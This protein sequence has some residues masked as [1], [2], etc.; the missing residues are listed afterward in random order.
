MTHALANVSGVIGHP[1]LG[2]VFG[3]VESFL[4]LLLMAAASGIYNWLQK[5][6]QAGQR[7]EPFGSAGGSGEEGVPRPARPATPARPARPVGTPRLW[8]E[9][10]SEPNP[11]SSP[12][13]SDPFGWSLRE[14]LELEQPRE[15]APP[16]VP[17]APRVAQPVFTAPERLAGIDGPLSHFDDRVSRDYEATVRARMQRAEQVEDKAAALDEDAAAKVAS[18]VPG[19]EVLKLGLRRPARPAP[20]N[21]QLA[22]ALASRNGLRQFIIASTILG[23][24]KAMGENQNTLF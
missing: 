10:P 18:V 22:A 7:G 11:T 21:P 9:T 12:A 20:R 16:V 3:S 5:R 15:A 8:S 2:W 23:P 24:P 4:V 1:V 14:F 6:G 19:P 17:V 13:S